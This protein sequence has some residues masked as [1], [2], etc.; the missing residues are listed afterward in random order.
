MNIFKILF[1]LSI[2]LSLFISCESSSSSAG[3]TSLL[4]FISGGTDSGENPGT[5]GGGSSNCS[6]G[7]IADLIG[8]DD[9]DPEAISKDFSGNL[10]LTGESTNDLGGNSVNSYKN[11]FVIKYRSNYL[12]KEWTIVLD[13]P[14]GNG[15]TTSNVFADSNGN[16]YVSG[17][18]NGN[19]EGKTCSGSCTFIG[20]LDSNGAVLWIKIFPEVFSKTN[21]ALD[22]SGNIYWVG[23]TGAAIN[24]Q[25]ATGLN[26]VFI[27]KIEPDGDL[28]TTVRLGNAGTSTVPYSVTIDSN[29]NLYLAGLT[30][31]TLEGETSSVSTN[32]FVTKYNSNLALQW[33]RLSSYTNMVGQV[34]SLYPRGI[35]TDS[36]GNIY[37]VGDS[38]IQGD[39]DGQSG[40]G[41]ENIFTM[42]YNSSGTKQW[43]RT[44]GELSGSAGAAS[45][46]ITVGPSGQIYILGRT[47]TVS[48]DSVPKIGNA[49]AFVTI[50]QPNGTKI[51][52]N[53]FGTSGTTYFPIGITYG[54]S[55]GVYFGTVISNVTYDSKGKIISL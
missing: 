19:L 41:F 23:S 15:G 30:G 8:T 47:S 18:T 21:I 55:E 14:A 5:G 11:P 22:P 45:G 44:L 42:K 39:I 48:F 50:Y 27:Q 40:P 32:L 24:G 6:N 34:G 33:V 10:Y 53:R 51:S 4:P 25:A 13:D 38:S 35:T 49:D 36:S 52:T 29:G 16:V 46:G 1:S 26:D 37:L 20:K 12:C 7:T 9:T 17:L 3:V 54:G 2:I 31:Y 28:S 43:T